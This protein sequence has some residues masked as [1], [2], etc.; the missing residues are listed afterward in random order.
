M[1][2]EGVCQISE[3]DQMVSTQEPLCLQYAEE[4]ELIMRIER[5]QVI[6]L[7]EKFTSVECDDRSYYRPES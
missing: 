1:V 4:N 5:S 3:S 2:Q 6:L 7:M